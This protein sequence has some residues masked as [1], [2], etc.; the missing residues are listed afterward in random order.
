MI[1][2]GNLRIFES[3]PCDSGCGFACAALCS[4]LGRKRR[5]IDHGALSANKRNYGFDFSITSTTI[6]NNNHVQHTYQ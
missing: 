1:I 5:P 3:H 4:L 2:L 6:Y